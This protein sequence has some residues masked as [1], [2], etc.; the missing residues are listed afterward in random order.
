VN[1]AAH[2]RL[3]H[4]HAKRIGGYYQTALA[5]H[6]CILGALPFSIAQPGV[7][8]QRLRTA[9]VQETGDLLHSTACGGVNDAAALFLGIQDFP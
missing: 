7:V 1:N 8:D 3:V 4:T 2:V 9:L 5:L 6:K